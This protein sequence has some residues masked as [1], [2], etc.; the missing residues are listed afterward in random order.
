[1]PL[2]SMTIIRDING[3]RLKHG[4]FHYLNRSA[5]TG[6]WHEDSTGLFCIDYSDSHGAYCA[7]IRPEGAA[8]RNAINTA[9][10]IGTPRP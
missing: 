3:N 7:F 10:A 9:T 2:Q 6:H 5:N 4:L 1:M 8:E